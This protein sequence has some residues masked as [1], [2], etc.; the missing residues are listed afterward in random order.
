MSGFEIHVRY[1]KYPKQRYRHRT[2]LLSPSKAKTSQR[3]AESLPD[4]TSPKPSYLLRNGRRRRGRVT[5]RAE[6]NRRYRIFGL[7]SVL[8]VPYPELVQIMSNLTSG[9]THPVPQ[10]PVGYPGRENT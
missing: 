9:S 8:L 5:P 1:H 10:S 3:A 4:H 6:V 2:P 7:V